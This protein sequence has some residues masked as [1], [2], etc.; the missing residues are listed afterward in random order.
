V[1]P[2]NERLI[3]FYDGLCGFCDRTVQYILRRDQRN[4]F[5]FAALQSDLANAKLPKYGK[6]PADLNTLYLMV[7]EGTEHERVLQK[8]DAAIRIGKELGGWTKVWAILVAILP[9]PIRDWG[10]DR[11][12]RSRYRIFGKLDACRI[13]AAEDRAKFIS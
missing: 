8:S 1:D 4:R 6:N 5:R 10:Y 13:P 7:G 12:A 2:T 3:V 9:R 11:V